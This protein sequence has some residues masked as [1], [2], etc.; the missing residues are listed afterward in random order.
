MMLTANGNYV[1]S[2]EKFPCENVTIVPTSGGCE[3]V[4]EKKR[5]KLRFISPECFLLAYSCRYSESASIFR[6]KRWL[7][8]TLTSSSSCGFAEIFA[9]F[10]LPEQPAVLRSRRTPFVGKNGL[11]CIL[12]LLFLFDYE[13]QIAGGLKLHIRMRALLSDLFR[14][15]LMGP[16]DY[17][18]PR[19]W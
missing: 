4:Y 1:G 15:P 19:R 16:R 18:Y 10:V 5:R 7:R 6:H 12:P 9:G 2:V 14:G 13:P 8:F 11:A 3:A 17:L